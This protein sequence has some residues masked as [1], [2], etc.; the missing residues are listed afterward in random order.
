M[1]FRAAFETTCRYPEGSLMIPEPSFELERDLE[2]AL[3]T[4]IRT[5]MADPPIVLRGFGLDLAVFT[6][7]PARTCFFEVKAFADH[8]GRCGIGNGRGEG[9]QIRLL[10]DDA[11]NRP[12][13]HLHLRA[14][15][16]SVRWIVGNRSAAIGTPRFLFFRCEEAQDA[17]MAG[18]RPGKQ[19]N[20]NL[21]RFKREDWMAWPSLIS[22]VLAFIGTTARSITE[23]QC[24][25]SCA[26]E[27]DRG[28]A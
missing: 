6:Q 14:L 5:G 28:R 24:V 26:G 22:N 12:R 16:N 3:V 4:A 18:V 21:S 2:T 8:H 25:G 20:L 11:T 19:S 1:I 10:F 27:P 23:G 7:S 9:N 13:D 15:D 17:V